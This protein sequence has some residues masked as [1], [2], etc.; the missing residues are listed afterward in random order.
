MTPADILDT[1]LREQIRAKG[2]VA[3]LRPC[4]V[5]AMTVAAKSVDLDT[6]CDPP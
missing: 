1:A 6:Y 3:G 4:P 2:I 5:D